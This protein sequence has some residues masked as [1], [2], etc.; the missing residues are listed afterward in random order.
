MGMERTFFVGVDIGGTFTDVVVSEA[1]G[2]R[3]YNAKTLTTP[4]NPVRGVMTGISDALALAQA[5]PREIA[6]V[7]HATTLATNLII[8]RKGAK[9]VFIT[10]KGFG[11]MF[12]IGKQTRLDT[13][14]YSLAYERPP[15]LV[16][17]NM[18]FEIGERLAADGE[19]LTALN[20]EHAVATL[21][22][23]AAIAPEAVAV[24]LLHAYLNP[25]HEN[26][27]AEMIRQHL[28]NAYLALSSEVWPEVGEYERAATT[29]ISAY[30]GPMF[31]RYVTDLN[32]ALKQ[33]GIGAGLE[34]MQ[35]SGGIMPAATAA[36]KAVYSIESGPAAG[37]IAASDLGRLCD[38]KNI[39]S[40]DM[41]GTTAKVALIPEGNPV[42]THDF[43]IGTAMSGGTRKGGE[44]V[45]VPVIDLAEVGAGGGSIAW[46]DSAGFLHVGPESAG[47]D[48][49]PAC[50]GFGGEQPTV[51]DADVVLGYFDPEY[52]LGG[53]MR[54]FPERSR[55]AIA[56]K[57]AE[58]LK[59]SVVEAAQGIYD[60]INAKMGSAIRVVTVRR[61]VDPREFAAVAFGG[62][63]P[64]H[65]IKVAE[66]FQIPLVIV[67][68]SPGVKSAFGLLVSDLAYDYITTRP[69]NC[70]SAD[71]S[72]VSHVIASMEEQARG[73]L[74]GA[75]VSDEAI[76]L[77][78][79]FDM[80][81]VHQR[82]EM[83]V[84]IPGGPVTQE[85]MAAADQGFRQ[86]YKD[87]FGVQ[88]ADPCQI[89]NFR[90]RAVGTVPK[91]RTPEHEKGNGNAQRALK[92][93]RKA[94]FP[95]AGGFVDTPVYDRANLKNGDM[96]AGPAIVEEPDSTTICPPEYRIEVD[97]F[98]SLLISRGAT[99]GGR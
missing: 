54:I 28:P 20:E 72:E 89:V 19:V 22:E 25:V 29:V 12:A 70:Q 47:A 26:R 10:T 45:K 33:S 43:R 17:R 95:Q 21:Q 94:Y 58:P 35:S 39:I 62:A 60:L 93:T 41:G 18:V 64:A 13:D 81:F 8:E 53:K 98:L 49:G 73:E 87:T 69:M 11:D 16:P 36:R 50:Y 76:Q 32:Q 52:F 34:I 6:R 46:V 14:F 30:V 31:S 92:K 85:T 97:R 99:L 42:I 96:I 80:R 68:V 48:P 59:L 63:G 38:R 82:H 65:I 84:P 5:Q 66:Q 91:A 56:R 74:K 61:G 24:C 77:Q 79:Y 71:P 1:A 3:V 75:A 78:R 40:F 44:P 23:I 88:P 51:T 55:E 67:P 37:V 86:I 7:V 90:I 15:A 83:P 4:S 27:L 2:E 57:V 9:L